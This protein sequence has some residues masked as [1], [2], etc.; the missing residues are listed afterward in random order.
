MCKLGKFLSLVPSSLV[1]WESPV[2]EKTSCVLH[3]VQGCLLQPAPAHCLPAVL[4]C[5][6]M[7]TPPKGRYPYPCCVSHSTGQWSNSTSTSFS[8]S[9]DSCPLVPSVARRRL[10]R[11][12]SSCFFTIGFF[13]SR[14]RHCCTLHS[15]QGQ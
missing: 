7:P 1:C 3:T 10:R 4:P 9:D 5:R 11:I 13:F 8:S 14:A 6:R 2:L 12:A 15:S